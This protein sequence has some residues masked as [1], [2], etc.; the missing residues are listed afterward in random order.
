MMALRNTLTMSGK[1]EKSRRGFAFFA[2]FP[3][4]AGSGLLSYI[5]FP[6]VSLLSGGG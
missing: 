3:G 5:I 4:F 1:I 6:S 2:L